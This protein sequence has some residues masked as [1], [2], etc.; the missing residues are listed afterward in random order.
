MRK[1]QMILIININYKMQDQITYQKKQHEILV[2]K[3]VMHNNI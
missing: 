3:M 1:I 2:R